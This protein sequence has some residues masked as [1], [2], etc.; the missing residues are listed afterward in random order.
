MNVFSLPEI[1]ETVRQNHTEGITFFEGDIAHEAAKQHIFNV[2]KRWLDPNGDGNPADGVD[3][4]RLDVAAE[5]PLGFWREY[6]KVVRSVNPEAYLVGELWWEKY[7]DKFLNPAPAL[8]GDVFDAAM[9]YRWYRS[10]RHF[11]NQAPNKITVSEYVDSLTSYLSE[12]REV[13][14]YAMM[15]LTASHDTPRFSTS[16][17]NKNKNKYR[18]K[19]A[20][21]PTYK[22]DRPDAE[23]WQTMQLILVQQFTYVGAPHIWNGDEMGM[24]GADDPSSRKPLLWPDYEFEPE[25]THP[26]GLE[27]PVNEVAFNHQW[28][29]FYR[30]LIQI[31]KSHRVLSHGKLEFVLIDD[32]RE[33][34]A[35]SRFDD[36][37]EVIAV[38]NTS[39]VEQNISLPVKFTGTYHSL[40]REEPIHSLNGELSITL[41]ARTAGIFSNR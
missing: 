12:I 37:N 25:T 15:N 2:T 34:L 36:A 20:D 27:R 1:R 30:Q 28:F 22:I 16:I 21:D 8:Q 41:P 40:L 33:L 26:L 19:P 14:N 3:G 11:F 38:F 5:I 4:F 6:R 23:T 10:T 24:W 13:N 29:D 31:R 39:E 17:Y 9:N 32:A 18:A 35:Y 7:P